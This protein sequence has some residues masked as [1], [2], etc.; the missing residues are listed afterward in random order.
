MDISTGWSVAPRIVGSLI[1]HILGIVLCLHCSRL[2]GD[3][4]SLELQ[5]EVDFRLQV[6]PEED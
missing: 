4:D 3:V 5:W 1:W 6:P 2:L